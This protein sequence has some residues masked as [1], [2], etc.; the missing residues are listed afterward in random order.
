VREKKDLARL[1]WALAREDRRVT[2][3]GLKATLEQLEVC[4]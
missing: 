4:V 1:H 3:A 2:S